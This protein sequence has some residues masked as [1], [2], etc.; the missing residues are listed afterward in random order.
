MTENK[1]VEINEGINISPT[2]L[3]SKDLETQRQ[4]IRIFD[5]RCNAN[6]TSQS[7]PYKENERH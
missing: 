5:P 3:T 6:V 4:K 7:R 1:H 2:T